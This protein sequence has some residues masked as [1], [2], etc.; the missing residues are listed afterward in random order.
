MKIY[1]KR[2]GG[3]EGRTTDITL[4]TNSLTPDESLNIKQLLDNAK[5]FDL[6]PKSSPPERGADYFR[7]KITVETNERKHTVE[8]TD[9]SMNPVLQSLVDFLN[10]RSTEE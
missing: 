1:F 9:L 2:S 3:F 4:N 10:Q 7:Y 5:F 8:T 6:P